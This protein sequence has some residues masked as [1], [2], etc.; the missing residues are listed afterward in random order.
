[1]MIAGGFVKNLQ[2]FSLPKNLQR[3]QTSKRSI[4]IIGEICGS[5]LD[6]VPAVEE[7]QKFYAWRKLCSL[8]LNY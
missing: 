5:I 1:M 6:L 3:M 2:L 4:G 8:I 7:L